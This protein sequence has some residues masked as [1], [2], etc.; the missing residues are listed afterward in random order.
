MIDFFSLKEHQDFH[1]YVPEILADKKIRDREF[2]FNCLNTT[3]NG[4]IEE[5][6]KK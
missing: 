2:F 1:H 5:L 3:F 6:V 4:K